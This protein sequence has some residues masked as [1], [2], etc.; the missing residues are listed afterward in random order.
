ME[1]GDLLVRR[2][3]CVVDYQMDAR[4]VPQLL[5]PHLSNDLNRQGTSTILGHSKIDRQNND[6]S[7]MEQVMF[8]AFGGTDAHDFLRERERSEEHTSE[9][10]SPCNLVCRLLLEKK[11]K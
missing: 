2:W 8:A 4:R 10:Q 9:L 5:D 3:I 7:W 6:V 11:K 1:V